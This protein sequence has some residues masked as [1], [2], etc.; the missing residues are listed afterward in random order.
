MNLLLEKIRH[1][2][3][4]DPLPPLF[5]RFPLAASRRRYKNFSLPSKIFIN[6]VI[7]RG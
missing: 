7:P 4:R 5:R 3:T 2:P 1:R 6:V